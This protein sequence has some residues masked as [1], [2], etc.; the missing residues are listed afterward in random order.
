M[1]VCGVMTNV[2]HAILTRSPTRLGLALP[3]PLVAVGVVFVRTI[4]IEDILEKSKPIVQMTKL[5]GDIDMRTLLV[6]K[7]H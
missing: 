4:Y 7:H 5:Y 6:S 1:S 2:V 3:T